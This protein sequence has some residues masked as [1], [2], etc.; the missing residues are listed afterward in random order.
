MGS[1]AEGVGHD[2][3]AARQVVDMQVEVLEG[4]NPASLAL[5]QLGLRLE[6]A[7]GLVVGVGGTAG[8][9]EDVVAPGPD[10]VD[11]GEQLFVVDGVVELGVAELAG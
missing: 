6:P 1:S 2:V 11:E 8:G 4:L 7:E 9:T 10:G 5:V 3:G